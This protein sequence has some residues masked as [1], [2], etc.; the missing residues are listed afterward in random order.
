[1]SA[2]VEPFA[3]IA[4]IIPCRN[5]LRVRQPAAHEHLF[6]T[7]AIITRTWPAPKISTNEACHA[8]AQ[9]P[10]PLLFPDDRDDR[11]E[12]AR[13]ISQAAVLVAADCSARAMA[14]ETARDDSPHD[15]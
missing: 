1:M 15:A 4:G 13:P 5:T 12:C 2:I 6:D 7:A 10:S 14:R 3:A 11:A 9:H 8:N